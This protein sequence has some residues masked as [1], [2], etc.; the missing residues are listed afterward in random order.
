MLIVWFNFM[1]VILLTSITFC[2]WVFFYFCEKQKYSCL[3]CGIF[4]ILQYFS[5]FF[6]A[7]FAWM[8]PFLRHL[9]DLGVITED[10]FFYSKWDKI[11]GRKFF[12]LL[13][14][15]IGV[16]FR[17][18]LNRVHRG[19][20]RVFFQKPR[21]YILNF[22][23]TELHL[24]IRLE[25]NP[26]GWANHNQIFL[27]MKAWRFDY[28]IV[29]IC[30]NI[31]KAPEESCCHSDSNERPSINTGVINA[32]RSIRIRLEHGEKRET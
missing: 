30:Q 6:V 9:T 11:C 32:Q 27:L 28:N 13:Q 8:V 24:G 1:I 23:S 14:N 12:R 29:D 19:F 10:M 20:L 17:C 5:L 4:L 7:T 2:F 18:D 26:F 22:V 25:K 21:T 16:C 3:R 31:E 15:E